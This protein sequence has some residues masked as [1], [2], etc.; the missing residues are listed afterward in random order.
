M[1]ACNLQLRASGS[2][3]SS[4]F[5]LQCKS[6]STPSLA[7]QQRTASGRSQ[8]SSS[9]LSSAAILRAMRSLKQWFLTAQNLQTT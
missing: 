3:S 9:P 2:F 4:L 7:A 8:G 6:G 5:W 1:C